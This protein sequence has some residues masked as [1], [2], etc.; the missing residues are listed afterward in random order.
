MNGTARLALAGGWLLFTSACPA[1][2]P[3]GAPA[4]EGRDVATSFDGVPIAYE[5]QGAGAPALVFVHGWSCDR[6]FWA[7]QLAP[8][9]GT[10]RVVA[11]DL[12]GHGESGRGRTDWTMAA[13]GNDV[14]GVVEKLA[15]PRVVLVGHSMG[16]DVITEA[17]RRLRGRVV[18]LIW[19]ETYR[20]LG[21]GRPPE[22]VEAFLAPFRANFSATTRGFVDTLF[23][24]GTDPALVER[25]SAE[26]SSRPPEIALSALDHAF[27]YSR[28][29]VRTLQELNLPVI[30]INADFL[31]TDVASMNRAGVKVIVMPGTG[32]FLQLEAPDRFNALLAEALDALPR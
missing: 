16:G 29:V 17:A 25:V 5:V 10:H 31:P 22:R 20:E 4:Q 18:G 14:A 8:F 6:S 23:R 3:S 19:V 28:E 15:L 12:A 11:L 27:S 26:M 21:A 7:G 1:H 32:H 24:P 2:R 30:A 13:F 9:S